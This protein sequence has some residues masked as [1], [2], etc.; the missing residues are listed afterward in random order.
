MKDGTGAPLVL[1]LLLLRL[2]PLPAFLVFPSREEENFSH[3]SLLFLLLRLRLAF[4]YLPP[5]RSSFSPPPPE[6]PE[7]KTE[8]RWG[9]SE[10]L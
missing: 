4:F 3:L 6:I 5:P 2:P 7:A 10:E 9:L 8:A 1:L